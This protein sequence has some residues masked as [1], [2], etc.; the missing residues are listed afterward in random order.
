MW[1]ID[2]NDTNDW[3]VNNIKIVNGKR[4]SDDFYYECNKL[5]FIHK[6]DLNDQKDFFVV[7][8]KTLNLNEQTLVNTLTVYEDND[9]LIQFCY[10][11]D[12]TNYYEPQVNYFS[13][14]INFCSCFRFHFQEKRF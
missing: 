11:Q 12:Y 5:P 14:I 6:L 3:P 4:N 13:T 10:H 2:I 1:L 7:L 8:G 9:S